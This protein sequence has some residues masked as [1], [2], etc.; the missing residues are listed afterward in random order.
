MHL[1]RE[2][3]FLGLKQDTLSHSNLVYCLE[4]SLSTFGSDAIEEFGLSGHSH[5]SVDSGYLS[6]FVVFFWLA[7]QED[8][9]MGNTASPKRYGTWGKGRALFFNFGLRPK[10][11]VY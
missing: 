2:S 6:S 4:Q 7:P 5:S 3:S 9:E 8:K 11:R 1:M 10:V